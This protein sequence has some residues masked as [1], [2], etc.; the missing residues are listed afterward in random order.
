VAVKP[1]R[2]AVIQGGMNTAAQRHFESE[3]LP[4]VPSLRRTAVRLARCRA[5]AEDLVQET[6]LRA[7]RCFHRFEPGTD[8][9]AWLF[10]ILYRVRIDAIRRS[11]RRPRT[12][13]LAGDGP[14]APPAP[15]TRHVGEEQVA[16]AVQ[17]L[18]EAFRSA[19]LLRDV[20]ELT[21]AEIAARLQVPVGTVMSRIHRGRGLLRHALRRDAASLGIPGALRGAA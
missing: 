15:E 5:D 7:Y 12:V 2:R 19:V 17:R 1:F 6:C 16:R 11:G 8:L 10:T 13:A 4:H 14:V 21:Y 9:R 20:H 3:A 18:P